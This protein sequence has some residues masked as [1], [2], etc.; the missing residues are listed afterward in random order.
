MSKE[1]PTLGK[2]LE[3]TM[4]IVMETGGKEKICEIK[5]VLEEAD[6]KFAA[7]SYG[8]YCMGA[9]PKQLSLLI[10]SHYPTNGSKK[11]DQ[12]IIDTPF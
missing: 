9:T 2:F 12:E 4:D 8:A 7:F 6:G 5:R 11:P 3:Q 10:F 1:Y